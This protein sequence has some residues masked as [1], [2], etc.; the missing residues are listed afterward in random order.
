MERN[1]IPSVLND[2]IS[3]TVP[4]PSKFRM[5]V[6]NRLLEGMK[7]LRSKNIPAIHYPNQNRYGN[8][9]EFTLPT[10]TVEGFF[11][12]KISIYPINTA[13]NFFRV[14]F[15]PNKLGSKGG[16]KIMK[17]LTKVL[18][19]DIAAKLFTEG[20][21]T[22]L[23]L[24]LNIR[25][26]LGDYFIY[27]KGLRQSSIYVDDV[28]ADA[29]ESQV[30]GSP[31]SNKKRCTLYNKAVEQCLTDAGDKHWWRL[32]IVLRNLKCSVAGIDRGLLKHFQQISFY[33]REILDDDSFDRRFLQ[34]VKARGL[35]FALHQLDRNTK[36]KYLRRL[37]KHEIH[38]VDLQRLGF[39]R[40]LASVSFLDMGQM[41]KVAA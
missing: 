28:D 23:D 11:D 2:K 40:G 27:M 30:L 13:H 19:A 24:A 31:K 32:E 15:N 38:P 37:A 34:Q 22:R 29:V 4:V 6:K 7:Y 35:N 20:R 5:T 14:E 41:A 39:K 25:K 3:I 8:N 12:L 16:R 9:F 33:S 21:V 26:P 1:K 36:E 17:I 10:D 18:G